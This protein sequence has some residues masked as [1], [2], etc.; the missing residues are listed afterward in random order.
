MVRNSQQ[1]L[2]L[3]IPIDRIQRS[4]RRSIALRIERDG[5]LT[6]CAPLQ[7][8]ELEIRQVVEK[9]AAWIHKTRDKL[10]ERNLITREKTYADGELF[11]YLGKQY[12][13]QLV[14]GA[15]TPL[16]LTN[17]FRLDRRALVNLQGVFKNWYRQQARALLTARVEK[18]AAQYGF[19]YKT[20]RIT[21]ARTRW[22]SCS[23]S[24]YLNF[25]WRLVQAPLEIIDSVILHELAHLKVRNHSPAFY[26]YLAQLNPAWKVH[27]Q[28]LK[29]HA[30]ELLLR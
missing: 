19:Q 23:S 25:S 10:R 18:Y 29:Q 6:V 5:S 12:P 11:W 9:H 16:E 8:T 15:K 3:M 13:L 4:R 7:A 28:W 24:G 26:A 14:E 27:R 1:T 22:G 2:N 20:L 21:S 17:H 30:A